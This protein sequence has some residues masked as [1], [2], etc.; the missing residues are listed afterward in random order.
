VE[1]SGVRH[2]STLV[3]AGGEVC[4]W[5]TFLELKSLCQAFSAPLSVPGPEGVTAI[6]L[7]LL[8]APYTI[9]FPILFSALSKHPLVK[10]END[11]P[12][13][14]YSCLENLMDRGAWQTIVHRITELDV[15]E[16]T[17]RA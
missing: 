16:A 5:S 10:S 7:M 1:S 3:G 2:R 14:Q 11:N 13:L 15:T 8:G 6:P 12:L 17:L 4:S 9:N